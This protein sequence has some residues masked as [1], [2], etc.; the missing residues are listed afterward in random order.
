MI[1][2]HGK[3]VVLLKKDASGNWWISHSIYNS[4]VPPPA[5]AREEITWSPFAKAPPPIATSSSTR[6]GASRRSGR[7]RGGRRRSWSPG[8]C[9][10]STTSS[11][12]ACRAPRCCIAEDDGIS[13]WFRVP[14]AGRG[15]F[16]RRAPRPSRHD[17]GD[18]RG[19]RP[20]RRRGA[21]ARRRA[22][23]PRLRLR[24]ADAQRLRRQS[25]RA[26]GLRA[27]RLPGRDRPL[28][29]DHWT[30]I[31][32]CAGRSCCSPWHSRNSRPR[33]SARSSPPSTPATPAALA[34]L[35]TA[36][37]INSGTQNF[38]G[39]RA[40]GDLFRKEFDALGFKTTWVDGS[41]FKR[42]G[43][44]VADHPGKGPRIILI[45]HLDTVFEPDSPFQKF[46]QIDEQDGDRP[47][48][49]RHEGG[50]RHHHRR[51]Q[52]AQGRRRA[53]RDERDRGHDR[54]RGGFRRSADRGA[55]R[56]GRRPRRGRSTRS[57]SRTVPAIRA[58]R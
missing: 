54:R 28:R 13:G 55:R 12:A 1:D 18:G 19:G 20:R 29:K 17:C 33:P 4:D 51:A 35:E 53:R 37:N 39:V 9:A 24:E 11:T 49:H 6:P 8:K 23:G 31:G 40:V 38:A 21:D 47:R 34:L 30:K 42:A 57:G 25:A 5:R 15:L 48:H 7:R 44:L 22:M 14:R 27:V 2:D 32:P 50:R 58:S 56:A 46:R 10:A 36:V 43:H 26:P 3:Y 52:G 16:Q 45:G 41:G